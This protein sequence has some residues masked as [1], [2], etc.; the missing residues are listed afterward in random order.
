[1]PDMSY[2][3]DLK[4]QRTADSWTLDSSDARREC[5][6]VHARGP[7]GSATDEGESA[8]AFAPACV[9]FIRTIANGPSCG[10]WAI[11]SANRGSAT[12]W[13]DRGIEA[14]AFEYPVHGGGCDWR[15]FCG[16][17]RREIGLG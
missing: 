9:A 7:D 5:S 11:Q 17:A 13:N 1:M 16:T 14:I 2:A 3:D 12:A 6:H 10:R 4:K 15:G 8:S